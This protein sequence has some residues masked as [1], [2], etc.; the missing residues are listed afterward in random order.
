MMREFDPKYDWEFEES[1]LIDGLNNPTLEHFSGG[2]YHLAREIIQNAIDARKDSSIAVQVKFKSQS[3]PAKFFPG[4]KTYMEVIDFCRAS[5]D[6]HPEVIDFFNS[7]ETI[8]DKE[9]ISFLKISDYNTTGLLGDEKD[10]NKG[11]VG[12]IKSRGNSPKRE[13]Q[14]GSFGIGKGAA[15]KASKLRTVFY[16]TYNTEGFRRFQGITELVSFEKN[17]KEHRGTGSFGTKKFGAINNPLEIP[18]FFQ[19][20]EKGLDIYL[21]GSSLNDNLESELIKSVLRN[22][23]YAIF[24]GEL[25]V[26]VAE[27][28]ISKETLESLLVEHFENQPI[29]DHIEPHGNPLTYYEA[30]IKGKYFR[31]VL[32]VIGEVS[33]YF[34]KTTNTL[35]H[36][37][38]IRKSH[39]V[40]YSKPYRHPEAFA[41]VFICDNTEG[42]EEL[43]KMEPPAHDKWDPERNE[44]NGR[45]IIE[46]IGNWIR[47]TLKGLR[48]I[49]T[50]GFQDIPGLSKYLPFNDESQTEE[51]GDKETVEK[52][53][54]EE[55][56]SLM[57]SKSIFESFP[58]INP[59]DVSVLNS[60]DTGLGGS[61]TVVR[62]KKGKI[63][64]KTNNNKTNNGSGAGNT[65]AVRHSSIQVRSYLIEEIGDQLTYAI[66]IN[67]TENSKCSINMKAVGEEGEESIEIHS[68]ADENGQKLRF[69][70][71]TISL[72]NLESGIKKKILVKLSSK[73]K[74]SLR[75]KVNDL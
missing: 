12:L 46:G 27:I 53:S 17:D 20:K 59:Y 40:I 19:R 71:S 26:E 44:S 18:E 47:S 41:G 25:I 30:V 24:R 2:Y 14:G 8:L 39:M 1:N 23:W 21:A 13:G 4:L 29:K 66:V 68:V 32:P 22:F 65:P 61:S 5:W 52:E 48:E 57:Q 54:D 49:Q 6:S 7:A 38:M 62:K 69:N 58:V 28:K 56:A 42:N 9:S 16:S 3:I 33:F 70:K 43:R 60:P 73:F 75:L 35:N 63:K 34:H 64:T 74:V 11:W 51:K 45:Q 67:P 10:K 15:F 31:K 37:A 55:T 50:S 72:I 36:V